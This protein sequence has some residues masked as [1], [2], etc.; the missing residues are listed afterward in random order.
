MASTSFLKISE[1]CHVA[2]RLCKAS[3]INLKVCASLLP[4]TSR[5]RP[6]A[7]LSTGLQIVKMVRSN[8]SLKN[9]FRKHSSVKLLSLPETRF[10][11]SF[12][13][14]QRFLRCRQPLQT[15]TGSPEWE[16]YEIQTK[17]V[18]SSC[19]VIF[20]AEATAFSNFISLWPQG[21]REAVRACRGGATRV[22]HTRHR[23]SPVQGC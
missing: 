18:C 5:H 23:H 6:G 12:L 20:R 13:L 10:A 22:R 9:L 14:L 3:A 15:T 1:N 19:S 21:H 11:Y 4:C 2:S 17:T 8:Q 7:F 16:R